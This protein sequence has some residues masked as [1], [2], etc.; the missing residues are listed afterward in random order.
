MSGLAVEGNTDNKIW[1]N[2]NDY[3]VLLV[4]YKK[5]VLLGVCLRTSCC[6]CEKSPEYSNHDQTVCE[7]PHDSTQTSKESPTARSELGDFVSKQPL[8]K[9]ALL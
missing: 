1:I 3:E 2:P 6:V 5:E 4:P 7:G 8:S 9:G